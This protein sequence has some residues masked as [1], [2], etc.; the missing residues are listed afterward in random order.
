M[1]IDVPEI[2]E[3]AEMGSQAENLLYRLGAQTHVERKKHLH[4]LWYS[5]NHTAWIQNSEGIPDDMTQT[6]PRGVLRISVGI[7]NIKV[8]AVTA[9]ERLPESP[10]LE[11]LQ[12]Y[13]KLL[14]PRLT[15]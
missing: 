4:G 8:F 7:E 3:P 11:N 9:S 13:L 15:L 6:S 14:H 1:L 12:L 10:G 5:R 2:P